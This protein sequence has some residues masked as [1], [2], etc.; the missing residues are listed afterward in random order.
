MGVGGTDLGLVRMSSWRGRDLP[1]HSTCQGNP[2]AALHGL[3]WALALHL[4]GS[5]QGTFEN[6]WRFLVTLC[7]FLG[8]QMPPYLPAHL[9][10]NWER[11][12]TDP[13]GSQISL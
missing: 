12:F 6:L 4:Q 3:L 9:A 5:G 8:L 2:F 1:L 10:G 13:S 11:G 7:L